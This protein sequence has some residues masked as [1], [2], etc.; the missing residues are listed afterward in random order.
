MRAD[1]PAEP[2]DKGQ[3]SEVQQGIQFKEDRETIFPF[4]RE[5]GLI[6]FR[7]YFRLRVPAGQPVQ[8][9]QVALELDAGDSFGAFG[10]GEGH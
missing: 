6:L 2:P 5:Q 7:R 4:D 10:G 9:G 8:Q 1:G 3:D